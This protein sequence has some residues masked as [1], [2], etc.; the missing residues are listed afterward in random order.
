MRPSHTRPL[1]PSPCFLCAYGPATGNRRAEA[2]L[3]GP[4]HHGRTPV[5]HPHQAHRGPSLGPRQDA[6]SGTTSFPA[7]ASEST[8][9]A[10]RSSSSRRAP[11][12]ARSASASA[13]M[14]IPVSPST[15]PQ[16][17]HRRHRAHQDGQPPVQPGP[18]PEPT[19]ADLAERYQ[20]EY[21]AMH[22][23]PRHHLA[24]PPHAAQAYRAAL[25]ERRVARSSTRTSSPFTQPAPDADRRQPGGRHPGQDVQPGGRVGLASSGANPARSV[26]RSRVEKPSVSHPRG[27]LRLG[28][29]LR[30]A[31]EK[32]LASTHA[33]AAI[34]LL[35][36]TGCRRNEILGSGGTTSTST[37]AR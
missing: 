33:A 15:T 28:E 17:G 29:A 12:A 18:A 7:S 26:P 8:P 1:L 35:V 22:C 24:L 6:S 31:P 27:A 25:G 2:R 30:A 37:P 20:R 4:P 32:R 14:A 11:S 36:L 23:K 5:P 10:R 3:E 34:R 16:E 19:V 21:V 9:P 13:P